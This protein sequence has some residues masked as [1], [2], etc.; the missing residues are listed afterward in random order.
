MRREEREGGGGSEGPIRLRIFVFRLG[1]A[2]LLAIA[3][4][5]GALPD[6]ARRYYT[7]QPDELTSGQR[8]RSCISLL[9]W[10]R[11]CV[12]QNITGQHSI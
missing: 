2:Q 7:E 9:G 6:G 4:G 1:V 10:K 5:W 3:A 8:R 11:H 12:G